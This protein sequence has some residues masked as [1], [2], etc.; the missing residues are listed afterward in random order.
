VVNLI[1]LQR[2]SEAYP[3]IGKIRSLAT[4][5]IRHNILLWVTSYKLILGVVISSGDFDQAGK[6]VPEVAAGIDLYHDKIPATDVV[7]FKYNMA[8]VYFAGKQYSKSV[9]TLNDIINDSE[10]SL[11]D[12]I[13]SFARL[14]RLIVFWEKGEQELLPYAV[15]SA[16]RF[17]Y[18]RKKLYKFESLVLQFIKEKIPSINTAAKQ[19]IAFSELKIKLEQLMLDPLEKKALEYFDF[20][21]WIESKIRR[22]DFKAV[23]RE[24]MRTA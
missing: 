6:I 12:D 3:H 16:Y 19:R 13:Q 11:R 2:I 21:S 4:Y 10:L 5:N 7:L 9:K 14:I 24:K 20:I 1:H 22:K 18:K 17:I 23:V 15:L 8:I